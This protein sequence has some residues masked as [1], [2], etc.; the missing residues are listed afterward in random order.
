MMTQ[1]EHIYT[2]TLIIV[3]AILNLIL[4]WA[5]LFLNCIILTIN[6]TLLMYGVKRPVSQSTAVKVV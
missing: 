5:L 6:C 2:T 4:I 1:K 3:L